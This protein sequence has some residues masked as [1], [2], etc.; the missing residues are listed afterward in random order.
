MHRAGANRQAAGRG[1]LHG[2]GRAEGSGPCGGWRGLHRGQGGLLL[3]PGLRRQRRRDDPGP[4]GENS[5]APGHGPHGGRA[6]DRAAGQR[7]RKPEG[8]RCG[9]APIRGDPLRHGAAFRRV[10]H[11]R[12]RDGPLPRPGHA[13]DPGVRFHRA[14]EKD[15]QNRPAHR[16]GDERRKGPGKERGAALRR[17]GNGAPGRM[18]P[19]GGK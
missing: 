9:A 13:D 19:H 8:R 17:G 10:P 7:R 15:G 11:D 3:R 14:G 2:A 6:R 4:G 5:Q 18:R 16:S 1:Q 12:L